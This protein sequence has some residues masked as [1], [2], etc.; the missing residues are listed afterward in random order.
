MGHCA[1]AIAPGLFLEVPASSL[2]LAP[3]GRQVNQI[4]NTELIGA[5][6]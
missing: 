6:D 4:P 1:P 3:N 5:L 2:P